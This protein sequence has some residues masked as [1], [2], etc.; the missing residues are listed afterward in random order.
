MRSLSELPL[1][2]PLHRL[3]ISL[4]RRTGAR[5]RLFDL[6]QRA[7][8]KAGRSQL[9]RT[10]FGAKIYCDLGDLIPSRIFHF[11]L[12]EPD[13]SHCISR[14][15]SDGDV[16]VDVGANLGYYSLL[17]SKIVGRTGAVVAIEA[18]PRIFARLQG[19]LA[20]NRAANVRAVNVAVS[21]GVGSVTIYSGPA[22]NSGATSVLKKWRN[23]EAEAVV[24][25][26][27]LNRILTEDECK[28][29]ALIK[30]DVEGA[31]A[32]I[33][34]QFL[35]SIECYSPDT[36]IIVEFN[37]GDG[38]L[39]PNSL[40][41]DFIARGFSAYEISNRYDAAWYLNWRRPNRMRR[42]DICPTGAVDILFL[43]EGAT[44]DAAAKADTPL[45]QDP[46]RRK[47]A[48]M[49]EAQFRHHGLLA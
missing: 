19:N 43:R 3:A 45:A 44:R 24:G 11:G 27:P 22:Q 29:V 15:L 33:L 20:A 17:A 38:E 41:S 28:R 36:A 9:A 2:L 12:W 18:S 34:S 8:K 39:T 25:A 48:R 1:V 46:N 32:P 6:Y 23:G 42:L 5:E 14:Y 31:E 37:P 4:I 10:K 35:S 16:F 47:P 30:I 13:I 7:W 21:A 26:L 40:F 49:L